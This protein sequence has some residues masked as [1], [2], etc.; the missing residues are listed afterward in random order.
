MERTCLLWLIT[1]ELLVLDWLALLLWAASPAIAGHGW[2][3]MTG[4]NCSLNGLEET[5]ATKGRQKEI[6][7]SQDPSRAHPQ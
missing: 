6:T 4:Q 5:T 1:L 3:S 7:D 2:G